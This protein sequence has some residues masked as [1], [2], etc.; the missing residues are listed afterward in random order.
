MLEKL[1]IKNYAL[2]DEIAINFKPG[3][4]V[5]TGETGAGK[6]VIIGA[7]AACL[8]GR[9]DRDQVRHGSDKAVSEAIFQIHPKHKSKTNR[10]AGASSS[11]KKA[12]NTKRLILRREISRSGASRAFLNGRA[13][14]LTRLKET[15]DGIADIHSQQGQRNLIDVDH[16]LDFLDSYLGLA[17]KR[18]QLAGFYSEYKA[19]Q[20]QL[21]EARRNESAMK[22]KLELVRFQIEELSAADIQPGQEKELELD[23]RRLDS[24][25]HIIETG[26]M[27]VSQLGEGDHD[28]LSR[29]AGLDKSLCEIA[30][31]DL[32]F[33]P[34][35]ELM[36]ESVISLNEMKQNLEGYL[37]RLSDD[38]A[39]LDQI[40]E[41]LA[42]IYQLKRK[43]DTDEA[44]LA[45]KLIELKKDFD[46]VSDY[47]SL[48]IELEG[49]LQ[50]A[51]Q[52]Y[53]ELALEISE[54]RSKGS[55]RME[56]A[57]LKHLA[58]LALS[59]AEF[60]IKFQREF[61]EDGFDLN[62]EK[63]A[64]LPR[65]LETIE[66]F[67]STNPKEPLRPLVKIASGGE[68]SRILLAILIVL[69]GK[70]RIPTIIFDEIDTGIGGQTATKLAEKLKELSIEHQVVVI[71]HLPVVAKLADNHLAV[72]KKISS[73]RNVIT[74]DELSGKRVKLELARMGS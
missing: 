57:I 48:I 32:Q 25:R 10:S 67:I 60:E 33:K 8:G 47:K 17:K 22:E 62:G 54:K 14:N 31:L 21:A 19:E 34:D 30:E 16:H 43:Y 9:I 28:I 39:R 20:R 63:V 36:T 55:A 56:K 1:T 6:S 41:R 65:G 42:E 7:L 69:A 27:I 46:G 15:A 18:D 59:K 35:A 13:I 64:G 50:K 71:S 4:S 3:L 72:S 44:G 23:R 51:R 66:F 11:S 40:N 2:V 29:L 37:S 26:Q 53:F 70:Y 49:R 68:L 73:G 45:E 38:P 61:D 5:L 58:D 74:V 12:E 24:M 52:S